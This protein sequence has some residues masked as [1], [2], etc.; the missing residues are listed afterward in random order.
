MCL[1]VTL[2]TIVTITI[3]GFLA[4]WIPFTN[5]EERLGK[6][7]DM[8]GKY[9]NNRSSEEKIEREV[10]WKNQCKSPFFSIFFLQVTDIKSQVVQITSK[11]LGDIDDLTK[12]IKKNNKYLIS[13]FSHLETESRSSKA[14]F[15]KLIHSNTETIKNM[16][17]LFTEETNSI[18]RK[19]SELETK[20]INI[21]CISN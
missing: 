8:T 12:I 18:R 19:I 10:N 3:A 6:V 15:E 20:G 5:M 4:F 14:S 13:K 16:S 17:E 2:I 11:Y 9:F 1:F 21:I 7:E